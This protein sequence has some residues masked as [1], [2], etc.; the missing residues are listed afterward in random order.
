MTR[1]TRSPESGVSLL[2]AILALL[3]LSAIGAAMM[4]STSTETS[5]NSNYRQEQI[6]YFGAKDGI[7]EA[8]ARMMATD[9]NTITSQPILNPNQVAAPST[10]NQMIY[11]IVNDG[12]VAN[13][14][15][16]WNSGNGYVDDELCHDGYSLGM[17]GTMPAPDVRCY[18][19]TAGNQTPILPSGTT[20]YGETNSALPFNGTSGA[21]PF[22]WV[23][24]APKLN[25]SAQY[26]TGAGS[27]ASVSTYSVNSGYSATN[28]VCW[29]GTEEMVLTTYPACNQMPS[30]QG[31]PMTNVYLVTSMGV[32]PSGARR[33]IQAEVALEPTPPF[34]YGLFATSTACPAI[35]FSGSN[36]STNSYT[37]ANG[38]TYSTTESNLG[39][40]IGSN[41]QVNVGN[42]TVGGI[43]G[44]LPGPF[45]GAGCTPTSPPVVIGPQGGCANQGSVKCTAS[46]PSGNSNGKACFLTQPYQFP[47]PPAPSPLPPNTAYSPPSCGKKS[48]G[49][50]MVPGTYGNISL[51]GNQ[52]LTMAP[53]VYNINSLSMEG[54]ASITVSPA[55]AVV[56]NVGGVGFNATSSSPVLQIAGNGITDNTIPNDFLINYGGY[57]PVN[58]AGNGSSTAIINAPN[59]PIA[60][61]GNGAW[62]GS[63]LGSTVAINGGGAFHFDLTAA[64]APANDG[65]YTLISYRQV[66]Y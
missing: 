38:G 40:D 50:C 10:G 48:S 49:L 18:S 32:S 64:L 11:Y 42:G 22:A 46:C 4:F 17:A 63:I 27:T 35:T 45:T 36:A 58:I 1:E 13:S 19:G 20:W 3:L 37:T 60:I 14:V 29:D 39:G 56:L 16:P 44:A 7:E 43:I 21:L 2:F 51:A 31:S 47:T 61:S 24:I 25:S 65:Y 53:G 8:R 6:A 23:R 59:A 5:I 55:G 30:A 41:G 62:F 12:A 52:A 57:A 28:L 26:L 54:N 66:P 33:V 15:Q 9:P 34:P